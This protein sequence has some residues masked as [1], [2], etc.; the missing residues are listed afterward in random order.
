[1]QFRIINILSRRV[2]K[3]EGKL[4]RSMKLLE[5]NLKIQH[6]YLNIVHNY[7]KIIYFSSRVFKWVVEY[8]GLS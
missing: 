2:V 7:I 3:L 4:W 6:L 1:M 5:R 8:F